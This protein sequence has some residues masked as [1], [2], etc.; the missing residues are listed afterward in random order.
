MLVATDLFQSRSILRNSSFFFN[1]GDI[2]ALIC[3]VFLLALAAV[4]KSVLHAI[5]YLPTVASGDNASTPSIVLY[6]VDL[7]VKVMF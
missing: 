7:K 6:V 5:R 4:L 2:S 1:R 3:K